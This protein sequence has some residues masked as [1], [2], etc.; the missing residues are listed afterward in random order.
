MMRI[1]SI[2]QVVDLENGGQLTH[3][4]TVE[5][6]GHRVAIS[7]D[8]QTVQQLIEAATGERQLAK[9]D[10]F[11]GG[12]EVK[13]FEPGEERYRQEPPPVDPGMDEE[14]A[15]IFG[16]DTDDTEPPKEEVVM[17]VVAEEPVPARQESGGLG[18]GR[19]VNIPSPPPRPR[20]D[21]DGFVLPVTART[22]DMDEMGY[23][24]TAQNRPTIPDDDG[25]D[26]GTQI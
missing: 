22:V 3:Q 23:P 21:K 12:S 5:F 20:V 2:G 14:M 1:V 19:P 7:T 6:H 4:F 25:A 18:T 24:V 8:E 15:A 10:P 11:E 26:D 16:G 13:H 9:R 17:G